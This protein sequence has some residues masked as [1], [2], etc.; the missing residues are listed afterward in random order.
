MAQLKEQSR[1]ESRSS[2]ALVFWPPSVI[3][4]ARILEEHDDGI[5]ILWPMWA[6]PPLK[7]VINVSIAGNLGPA[8]VQHVE[9]SEHEAPRVSLQWSKHA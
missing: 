4:V 3:R 1:R 7:H 9:R 5:V 2:A 6:S 8:V